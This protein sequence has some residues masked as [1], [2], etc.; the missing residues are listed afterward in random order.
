M[1]I[2]VIKL[3]RG[4]QEVNSRE[5]NKNAVCLE[6]EMGITEQKWLTDVGQCGTRYKN[7]YGKG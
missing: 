4:H 6:G 3:V 1:P 7:E 2:E 5:V